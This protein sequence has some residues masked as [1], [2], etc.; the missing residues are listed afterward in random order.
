MNRLDFSRIKIARLDQEWPNAY[1]PQKS[2]LLFKTVECLTE[3]EFSRIIDHALMNMKAAPSVSF[4]RESAKIMF[5]KSRHA[6][7]SQDTSKNED[8]VCNTCNDLGLREVE[9]LDTGHNYF[10]YCNCDT[11]LNN[12]SSQQKINW[13]GLISINDVDLKK[14]RAL[15]KFECG[16]RWKPKGGLNSS[17][18]LKLVEHWKKNMRLSKEHW[19]KTNDTV[20]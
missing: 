18:H 8:L 9:R 1:G 12:K 13:P 7:K 17:D 2:E 14:Y 11:L 19:T 6:S 5:S 15:N 3:Y 10:V 4:F 16:K 20:L